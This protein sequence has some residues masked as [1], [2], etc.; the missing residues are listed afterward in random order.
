MKA[1][2]LSASLVLAAVGSAQ[3]TLV[4]AASGGGS[5]TEIQPAIAAAAPGDIVLVRAGVY[6]A[7]TL[8]KGVRVI[9]EPGARVSDAHNHFVVRDVPAGQTAV[10]R[11]IEAEPGFGVIAIRDNQGLVLIEDLEARGVTITDSR[12]VSLRRVRAMG[13]GLAAQVVERSVVAASECSFAGFGVLRA[14]PALELVDAT[15]TWADGKL[16]GSADPFAA[17]G[18]GVLLHSGSLTIAGD[19]STAVEAGTGGSGAE[20]AIVALAGQLRLDPEVTLT[21]SGGSPA[22]RGG[23]AVTFRTTPST[24]AE[25]SSGQLVVDLRAP[26]AE[27]GHLVASPPLNPPIALPFGQLWVGT[28]LVLLDSGP[29]GANGHR[30]ATIP[31]PPMPAGTTAALQ[32]AVV[33]GGALELST[34]VLPTLD[35]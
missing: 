26:G 15:V 7:F 9:G 19:A 12:H 4:V 21:P 32:W 5:Y 3:Q 2:V 20:S 10:V 30:T 23:A 6:M 18:P 34:P 33:R 28:N 1:L 35:T 16:V 24:R 13:P 14:V 17:P 25:V 27:T 8:D 22:V 11:A 31:L 29:I